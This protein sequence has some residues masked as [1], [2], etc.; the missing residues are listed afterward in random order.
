MLGISSL[1]DFGCSVF[2]MKI[3]SFPKHEK[4]FSGMEGLMINCKF[5]TM[6]VR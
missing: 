1:E 2:V 3:K 6:V 4:L 5:A